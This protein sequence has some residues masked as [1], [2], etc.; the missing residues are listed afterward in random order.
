MERKAGSK[1]NV[2]I[3]GYLKTSCL[4]VDFIATIKTSVWLLS[5]KD[6]KRFASFLEF[7]QW[8][9]KIY[10]KGDAKYFTFKIV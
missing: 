10:M 8:D 1:L 5:S 3:R 7:I 6:M 4:F 9:G 2:T